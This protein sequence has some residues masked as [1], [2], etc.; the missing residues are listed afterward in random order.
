[1]NRSFSVLDIAHSF[2]RANVQPGD[3]CIDATAGK[4]GDTE[5][6][7]S[8]VG[9]EGKVIAFDIQPA[10]ID[11]A[12]ERLAKAWLL[13]RAQFHLAGHENMDKYADKGTVKCI[14]FNLG[15]LPG[16]DHNIHTST[17]TT[18]KAVE[19]GLEL[20]CDD[21]VM[22]ISVYYGRE[23]GYEEKDA[24]LAYLKDI[25]SSEYTVVVCDF[26]NRRNCPPFPI[27][28]TKGR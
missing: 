19:R 4:G 18:L 11:F 1:M 25:D 20:L 10:A 5:L 27:L 7:C 8:L 22:C 15:W 2:I 28:I 13:D 9:G 16:G 14:V 3:I 23:T 26:L 6:L 21:G 12:K 17:D 24:L